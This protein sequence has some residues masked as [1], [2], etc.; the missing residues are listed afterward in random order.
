[1]EWN[2]SGSFSQEL[3]DLIPGYAI[4]LEGAVILFSS[5]EVNLD[6]SF[7]NYWK[8]TR[9]I[10]FP[11]VSIGIGVS[12]TIPLDSNYS[13]NPKGWAWIEDVP[14]YTEL[15]ILS[16]NGASFDGCGCD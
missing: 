6:S 8:G 12:R 7:D 3:A 11:Q 4:A 1:M 5:A 10:G 14:R 13:I 16:K 15:D 2:W 9:G